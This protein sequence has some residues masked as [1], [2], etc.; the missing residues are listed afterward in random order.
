MTANSKTA[1][2]ERADVHRSEMAARK[3]AER[4]ACA[5]RRSCLG[6]GRPFPSEGIHNRL[7]G[8]CRRST[9]SVGALD[10]Y[11]L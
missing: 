6:C 7:C 2:R 11:M 5:V 10:E 3:R 8:S 1:A 4:D 9:R